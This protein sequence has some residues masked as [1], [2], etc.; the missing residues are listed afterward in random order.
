MPT[1]ESSQK[2]KADASSSQSRADPAASSSYGHKRSKPSQSRACAA[3]RKAKTRCE[4]LDTPQA[5]PSSPNATATQ[6]NVACHRC[7]VVKLRCSFLPESDR[8][9]DPVQFVFEPGSALGTSGSHRL[10]ER[11]SVQ[12]QQRPLA[13]DPNRRPDGSELPF[14]IPLISDMSG[15]VDGSAAR[16]QNPDTPD[17]STVT[18]ISAADEW[19]GKADKIDGILW[20][21]MEKETNAMWNKP[22][23]AIQEASKLPQ[24]PSEGSHHAANSTTF[25]DSSVDDF[26]DSE[27]KHTLLRM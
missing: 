22:V 27:Q 9:S 3:C 10:P 4:V 8:G 11:E 21:M 14:N 7:R 23:G 18:T 26:L 6:L 25:H 5:S 15:A 17:G 12:P 20:F 2:R 16:S 24:L 19:K 1:A 13:N